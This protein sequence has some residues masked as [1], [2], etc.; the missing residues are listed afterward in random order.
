VPLAPAPTCAVGR[1]APPYCSL[2]QPE[3]DQVVE[4]GPGGRRALAAYGQ[5][6]SAFQSANIP[7][8]LCFQIHACFSQKPTAGARMCIGI[9]STLGAVGNAGRV[10]V[11]P[12]DDPL[13][14]DELAAAVRSRLLNEHLRFEGSRP[15][16]GRPEGRR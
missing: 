3:A 9:P 11:R 6:T 5:L 2:F 7:A 14:G 16:C 8:G 13:D 15:L 4:G 12:A 10:R 1:A